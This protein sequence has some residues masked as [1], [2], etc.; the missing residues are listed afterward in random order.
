MMISWDFMGW[1]AS[2]IIYHYLVGGDWNMTFMTFHSVGNVIIPTDFYIFQMGWNHGSR[3]V[4]RFFHGKAPRKTWMFLNGLFLVC[5]I[6]ISG[7]VQYYVGTIFMNGKPWW[8][9]INWTLYTY[10]TYTRIF[11]QSYLQHDTFSKWFLG[12]NLPWPMGMFQ[13]CCLTLYR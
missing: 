12:F 13:P 7:H 6:S 3:F 4:L 2:I 1:I 5:G 11:R 8:L 9:G 10:I